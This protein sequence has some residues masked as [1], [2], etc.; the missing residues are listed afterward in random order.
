MVRGGGHAAFRVVVQ[1]FYLDTPAQGLA[2]RRSRILRRAWREIPCRDTGGT[3]YRP[4]DAVPGKT[5][6]AGYAG[7][8]L[9]GFRIGR[10]PGRKACARRRTESRM[11]YG[12]HHA[13]GYSRTVA[14]FYPVPGR[15][16]QEVIRDIEA[17]FGVSVSGKEKYGDLV[18]TGFIIT[19]DMDGTLEAV[20]HS[21]GIPYEISGTEILLK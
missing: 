1:Q 13:D 8:L 11:R 2:Q 4:R 15:P 12:C 21:C 5:T 10:N 16:A 6:P 20:F 7:F 18:F 19:S 17:I 14:A 9:R 3:D